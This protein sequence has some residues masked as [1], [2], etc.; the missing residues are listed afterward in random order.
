MGRLARG[1][2]CSLDG[3]HLRKREKDAALGPNG[4]KAGTISSERNVE[5]PSSVWVVTTSLGVGSTDA[6]LYISC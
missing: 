6:I 5:V 2:F 3:E 4:A 1:W